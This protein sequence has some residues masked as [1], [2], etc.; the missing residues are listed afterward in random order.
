MVLVNSEHNKMQE[1][2]FAST[3]DAIRFQMQL[4]FHY[5]MLTI[6]KTMPQNNSRLMLQYWSFVRYKLLNMVDRN[7]NKIKIAFGNNSEEN[8]YMQLQNF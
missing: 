7:R 6:L 5:S 2:A 8:L 3:P 1:I 4:I